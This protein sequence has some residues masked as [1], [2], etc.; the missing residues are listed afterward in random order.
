MIKRDPKGLY[1]QFSDG[2]MKNIV[3]LDVKWHKPKNPHIMIDEKLT[4]TE[5][6]DLVINKI[7]QF[8]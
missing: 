3:G 7:P 8:K 4:L 2:K 6:T 5:S 1:K